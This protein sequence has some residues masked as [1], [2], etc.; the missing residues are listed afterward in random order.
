LTALIAATVLSHCSTTKVDPAPPLP[1]VPAYTRAEHPASLDWADIRA[2][3]A[4]PNATAKEARET[5]D[6]N[7]KK[8]KDVVQGPAELETGVVELVV[9]DPAAY[10]WCFYSKLI[11]L[12]ESLKETNSIRDRQVRVLDAYDFLVPVARAFHYKFNDTRYV[13]IAIHFYKEYSERLFYRRVDLTA[14]MSNDLMTRQVSNPFGY[15]RIPGDETQSVLEK[16]GIKPDKRLQAAPTATVSAPAPAAAEVP[17]APRDPA[18]APAAP[19]A[20]P[21]P[22]PTLNDLPTFE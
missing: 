22:A 17:E 2:V 11:G 16:Y 20:V 6:A 13:R 10:H 9:A 21:T 12:H 14:R 19:A 5:C 7:Y 8:L 4:S 18:A 3:M 1:E 15:Y